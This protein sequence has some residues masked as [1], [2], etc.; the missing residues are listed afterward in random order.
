MKSLG[1]GVLVILCVLEPAPL[2]A[3]A[4]P[5]TFVASSG[6]N[7]NPCSRTSPCR[8]FGAAISQ[9]T[10]GGEVIVLDSAGYGPATIGTS[11]PLVAPPGVYAGITATVG[12][13]IQVNAG[14]SDV[15]A[16]RGLTINGAGGDTG[17]YF[18]SGAALYVQQTLVQNFSNVGI[19]V[20]PLTNTVVRIEDATVV[21]SASTGIWIASFLTA[22]VK[23]TIVDS[24]IGDNHLAGNGTDGTFT[25]TLPLQ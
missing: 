17:I 1:L 7:T 4:A 10:A 13:G 14:A 20:G 16:I 6:M 22:A 3:A 24:R 15:I 25:G 9:T 21:R 23:A 19:T 5:R 18:T 12:F 2:S 8:S 11:V